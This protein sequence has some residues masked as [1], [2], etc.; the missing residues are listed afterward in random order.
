MICR[1]DIIEELNFD[2]WLV[3]AKKQIYKMM[4]FSITN[5]YDI[6]I[7][8]SDETMSKTNEGPYSK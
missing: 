3:L 4:M 7:S 5:R 2:T 8:D 1:K 6:L